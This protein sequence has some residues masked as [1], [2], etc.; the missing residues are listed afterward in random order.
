MEIKA[1]KITLVETKELR[2]HPKNP[3]KHNKEQIDRLCK[4]IDAQGFRNPI[5]VSNQ[6]GYVIAGHGRLMAAK[7]LGMENVPV[8]YE[9]FD[10]E[11]LEY[12]HMTADN[13]IAEWAELDLAQINLELQNIGPIDLDLLGLKDF[14]IDIS[15]KE[16]EKKESKDPKKIECPNCGEVFER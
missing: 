16:S 15:E 4:I 6:T 8:I 10:N 5:V 14:K 9:D 11:D 2:P 12:L 3:N 7:K 1:E 13:A